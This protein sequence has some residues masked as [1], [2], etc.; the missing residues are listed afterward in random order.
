M[1]L[2]LRWPLAKTSPPTEALRDYI[3]ELKEELQDA[4]ER[5]KDLEKQFTVLT[6]APAFTP[7]C[8]VGAPQKCANAP[9]CSFIPFRP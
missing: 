1:G 5:L 2:L 7:Q 4:E 8:G 6:G 9:P 3:A